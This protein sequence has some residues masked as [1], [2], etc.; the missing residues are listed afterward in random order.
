MR[1]EEEKLTSEMRICIQAFAF[2]VHS[3]Q[4]PKLCVDLK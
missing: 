3:Q 1:K 4:L 2:S